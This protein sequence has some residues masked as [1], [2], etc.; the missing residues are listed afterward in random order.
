M[1]ALQHKLAEIVPVLIHVTWKTHAAC[2]Q[3]VL[4]I[5]IKQF[6]NAHPE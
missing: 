1:S 6:A 5:I 3:P 2:K 4:Q